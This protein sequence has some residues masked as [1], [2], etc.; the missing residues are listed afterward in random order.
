MVARRNSS[1]KVDD[2]S[3]TE[4]N[5]ED[6]TSAVRTARLVGDDDPLAHPAKRNDWE[7][8]NLEWRVVRDSM[9]DDP[10][11]EEEDDEWKRYADNDV[12]EADDEEADEEAAENEDVDNEEIFCENLV[13]DRQQDQVSMAHRKRDAMQ[14]EE[15]EEEEI[16]DSDEVGVDDDDEVKMRNRREIDEIGEDD[17]DENEKEDDDTLIDMKETITT[18]RKVMSKCRQ[19]RDFPSASDPTGRRTCTA[20]PLQN[21]IT[22]AGRWL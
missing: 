1:V 3:H 16:D 22:L 13:E 2:T 21:P 18:A 4:L 7:T 12:E 15:S 11:D 10:S 8:Q 9:P 6:D 17:F 5:I 20:S 19:S 14:D